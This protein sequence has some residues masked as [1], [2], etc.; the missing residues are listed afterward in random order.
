MTTQTIKA[1]ITNIVTVGAFTT[2]K[3]AFKLYTF[4]ANDFSYTFSYTV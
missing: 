3:L 2:G 4:S 1:T